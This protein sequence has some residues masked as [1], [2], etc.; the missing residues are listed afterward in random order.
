MRREA[1]A[2]F[3]DNSLLQLRDS[4]ASLDN[5]VIIGHGNVRAL[6]K[7]RNVLFSSVAWKSHQALT[8]QAWGEILPGH[9]CMQ[10]C[11]DLFRDSEFTLLL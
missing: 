5:A 6:V 7:R 10:P 8:G 1:V 2:P 11:A 9:I 4:H 3:H